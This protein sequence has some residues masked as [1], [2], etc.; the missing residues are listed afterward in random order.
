MFAILFVFT[1]FIFFTVI[2]Q[3][4]ISLLRPRMGVLWSWFL[5]P[6][7]GLALLI[8]IMTRLNIWGLPVKTFGPWLAL[9][10]L[11]FSGLIFWWRRPY[12]P[13]RQLRW[14]LIPTVLFVIYAGWPMM[15]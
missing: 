7:V 10:L 3:A 6:T 14:F 11:V 5:S 1:L 9:G 12:F 13:W 2:G 15:R 8:V 4:V